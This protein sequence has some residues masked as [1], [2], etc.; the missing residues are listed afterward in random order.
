MTKKLTQSLH[1]FICH[2]DFP[3]A[4]IWRKITSWCFFLQ[5]LLIQTIQVILCSWLWRSL[6][7][8]P[9]LNKAPRLSSRNNHQ[10]HFKISFLNPRGLWTANPN[11]FVRFWNTV[12]VR[13]L[14]STIQMHTEEAS[15]V[16]NLESCWSGNWSLWCLFY[17]IFY[18]FDQL[19]MFTY[20]EHHMST[21]M[22]QIWALFW[23]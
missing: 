14:G 10:L 18:A 15:M 8:F 1:S 19:R 20:I 12:N 11:I 16:D 13:N 7:K 3:Q 22:S 23:H 2:Y 17:T 6:W 4:M 21:Q 9:C 5:G